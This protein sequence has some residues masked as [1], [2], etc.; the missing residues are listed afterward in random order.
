M[1][2][3][4]YP[5][6]KNSMFYFHIIFNEYLISHFLPPYT[7]ITHLSPYLLG[8]TTICNAY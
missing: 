8:H 6:T 3:P 5:G 1:Y 7:T 2:I 4:E